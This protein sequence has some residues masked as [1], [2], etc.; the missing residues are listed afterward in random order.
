MQVPFV[1]PE[2]QQRLQ[3]LRDLLILDTEPE[4]RFDVL[5][6]Y[7]ADMFEVPIVLV[8]LVD[9]NRQWFK[10]RCGLGATETPR[11]ISFCGHAI[12]ENEPLV[13]ADALADPRFA[14]NPLVTND[15]HIR[16]Y[17]GAPLAMENGM[18]VGTLCLIGKQSRQLSEWELGHLKD[19]AKVVA[20]ELQGIDASNEFMN[21][22]VHRVK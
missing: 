12:L 9:E 4:R 16:F 5:T 18:K 20:K 10:S 6:Q 11:N 15:P 8:S 1:P 7:A 14:D 13:V 3:T 19:L 17:A 2:E 21:S 22:T